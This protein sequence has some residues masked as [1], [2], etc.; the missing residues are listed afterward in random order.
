MVDVQ[1]MDYLEVSGALNKPLGLAGAPNGYIYA[2][3]FIQGT[4]QG[5]VEVF[6]PDGT[7]DAAITAV[8]DAQLKRPVGLAVVVLAIAAV[9]ML[10][11]TGIVVAMDAYGP[12]T[13]NAGGIAEMAKLPDQARAITDPLDA[14]GNT[15]K[16]T[17]K[18][19]AV[20]SAALAA[21]LVAIA[22]LAFAGLAALGAAVAGLRQQ[23]RV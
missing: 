2:T 7:F 19:F 20:M 9:S 23:T 1:G 15:T 10:S 21:A 3:S 11:L 5:R 13:D 12:I 18:A 14:V 22:F 8:G 6:K 17:T 16:A 4:L